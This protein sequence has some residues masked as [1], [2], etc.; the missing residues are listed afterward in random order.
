MEPRS[1]ESARHIDVVLRALDV[2]D[3]FQ[4][5]SVVSLKEIIDRTG[6]TRSRA[7]R[8]LGTLVSRGYLIED[9]DKRNYYLG[10]K[11]A[12]L[13]N[14]FEKF[15]NIEV[16]TRPVLKQLAVK[17]GESATLF[18]VDGFERVALIREEG[19]HAIRYSVREGQRMPLHV[20]AA[21]KIL[22]AFG[23]VE[24][25]QKVASSQ[26]ADSNKLIKEIDAARQKGYAIT[27]GENVPDAHAIAAPVIDYKNRLIG[28]IGI[29]GPA[30]RLDDN[31]IKNRLK[32]VR[33]AAKDLC[34]KF[35]K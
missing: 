10:I 6:V 31:Q 5:D 26:S 18:V 23:P 7:M 29:A 13:G 22:L 17:T 16:I 19:T 4:D 32:I 9:S 34:K 24:L 30:H 20:G 25:A 35:G 21:A 15:N 11:L 3:C 12:I 2:L 14:S 27:K 1:K 33:E 28:A 8:L